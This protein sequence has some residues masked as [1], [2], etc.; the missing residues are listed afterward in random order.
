MQHEISTLI[1]SVIIGCIYDLLGFNRY[2]EAK[3]LRERSLLIPLG[4]N[5]GGDGEKSHMRQLLFSSLVIPDW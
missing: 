3:G 2:Y 5:P 4:I 1:L